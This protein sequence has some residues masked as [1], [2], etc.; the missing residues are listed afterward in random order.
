MPGTVDEI[1]DSWTQALSKYTDDQVISS[2]NHCIDDGVRYPT[3][4]EIITRIKALS[5]PLETYESHEMRTHC[6]KCGKYRYCRRDSTHP[7][8]ECEDCYTGLTKAERTQ[9]YHD[10]IVKMGWSPREAKKEAKAA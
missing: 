2:V 9:R 3:P 4:G 7:K 1:S 5:P 10:L 6:S 8:Y